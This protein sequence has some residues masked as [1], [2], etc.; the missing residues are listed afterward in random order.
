MCR[1]YSATCSFLLGAMANLLYRQPPAPDD[2]DNTLERVLVV[3]LIPEIEDFKRRFR[4]LVSTTWGGTEMNCPTRS[5]FRLP[6]ARTCGRVVDD[7]YEVRI[8]DGNDNELPPGRPGE[9]IVRPKKPWIIMGGYWN[10][11]EWTVNAWRNLWLHTG[12]MLMRDED[13]YLYFVDRL[14]DAIRRSGENISSVEVEQEINAHQDVLESAVI[15]VVS[16]VTEQEVMA[17]IVL[18][19]GSHLAP[20]ELVQFLSDRIPYFMVPRYIEFVQEFPKTP[21]GKV[22]KYALRDRG[23][24]DVTWDRVKAGI[25]LE[26]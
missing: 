20:G 22:Q 11:P 19:P 10:H 2:G 9:A 7:L 1:R 21:T 14:K 24:T 25:K 12:D 17:V 6:N 23:V 15:P 5:G 18:K 4:L 3:P 13:G 16:E 8:V 26:K